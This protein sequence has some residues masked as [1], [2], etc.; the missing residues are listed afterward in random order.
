MQQALS[1]TCQAADWCV[2][3]RRPA[4]IESTSRVQ[5]KHTAASLSGVSLNT[6]AVMSQ[7]GSEADSD[8]EDDVDL[9]GPDP[10]EV[11]MQASL[12]EANQDSE[13][14]LAK[15]LQLSRQDNP[16]PSD[17][18]PSKFAFEHLLLAIRNRTSCHVPSAMSGLFRPLPP[19]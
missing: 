17:F 1:N 19:S 18:E 3:G 16:P 12:A 14:E 7:S 8:L 4:P 5:P 6:C 11:A 15:V 2:G 9:D 10:F 13:D